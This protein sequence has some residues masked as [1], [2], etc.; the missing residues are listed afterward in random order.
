MKQEIY[1]NLIEL[2]DEKLKNATSQDL[3]K[4]ESIKKI[5]SHEDCF[6]KIQFEVAYNIL[7]DLGFK[8]NEAMD[9]YKKLIA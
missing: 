8:K 3:K 2:C 9:L 7:I 5:L 4:F 1:K 6:D